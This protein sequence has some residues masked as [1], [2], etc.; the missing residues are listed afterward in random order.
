MSVPQQPFPQNAAHEPTSIDPS[1][2]YPRFSD[3]EFG[4]RYAATRSVMAE[5]GVEALLAFGSPGL[6][7]E[8]QYLTNFRVTR[9]ALLLFLPTERPLMFVQY[10]NH[11][12]NARR[13]S[14]QTDV[15]WGGDDTARA[16]ADEL[17]TRGLS[18]ARV[19][20]AGMLPTQRYL[21]LRHLLPDMT[22]ID[23]ST[24][25]RQ[26]R[27]VKSEEE[28]ACL[29]R[30]AELTDMAAVALERHAQPGMTEHELIALTVESPGPAEQVSKLITHAER[31][32]HAA[33]TL[34]HGVPVTL[35][36][37]LNGAALPVE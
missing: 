4:R 22:L 33:Q 6:D 24:D 14:Y 18:A 17:R 16:L 19:G 23:L 10:F 11:V 13:V 26:L 31:A 7:N 29:R 27:L 15:R 30:G 20:Y 5:R 37:K 25:L 28:L 35:A 8:V 1:D 12:P 9:E 32:C 2:L 34:R 21:T 3:A 36:A